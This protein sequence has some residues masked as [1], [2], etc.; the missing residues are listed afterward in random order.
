MDAHPDHKIEYT[1]RLDVAKINRRP[2]LKFIRGCGIG[3]GVHKSRAIERARVGAIRYR[4]VV[5]VVGRSGSF[6]NSFIASAIG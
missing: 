5:D 2:R 3:S 1:A 6:V 4:I